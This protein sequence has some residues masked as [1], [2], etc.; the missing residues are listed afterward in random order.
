[1]LGQFCTLAIFVCWVSCV[2][3]LSCWNCHKLHGLQICDTVA[4]EWVKS[5]KVA[6]GP[7]D[8]WILDLGSWSSWTWV[9]KELLTVYGNFSPKDQ[10]NIL[11]VKHKY[12]LTSEEKNLTRGTT[13]PG[14]WVFNLNYLVDQIEFVSIL[15]NSSFRLDCVGWLQIWPPDGATCIDYK[16]HH[17]LQLWPLGGATCIGWKLGHQVVPLAFVQHLVIRWRHLHRL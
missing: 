13:E 1:M 12:I 11:N 6:T 16:F 17:Q 14:Y 8:H 9:H 10:F 5:H 2:H 15:D 3:C 7:L 4:L